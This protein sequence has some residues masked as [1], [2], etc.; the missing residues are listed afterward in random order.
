MLHS[1]ASFILQL[2][3]EIVCVCINRSISPFINHPFCRLMFSSLNYEKLRM[4]VNCRHS[5]FHAREIIYNI[6]RPQAQNVLI[7]LKRRVEICF[8]PP[9]P[10]KA[11]PFKTQTKNLDENSKYK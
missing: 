6:H 1:G 9:L 8:H 4:Y 7:R 2:V 11:K 3:G 5:N 10:P